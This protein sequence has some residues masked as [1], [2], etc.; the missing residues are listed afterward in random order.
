MSERN[1]VEK[2]SSHHAFDANGRLKWRS[3]GLHKAALMS[4]V[5][6][7]ACNAWLWLCLMFATI[8][9]RPILCRL[10]GL[11]GKGTVDVCDVAKHV[12]LCRCAKRL[13]LLVP[14]R[15]GCRSG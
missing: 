7:S 5:F 12:A 2:R 15:M 13:C 6:V 10:A 1:E 8:P 9:D 11:V 3:L 4:P 14:A